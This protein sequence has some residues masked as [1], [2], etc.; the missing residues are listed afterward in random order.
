MRSVKIFHDWEFIDDGKTIDPIS[1]GMVKES[2]ES[3]FAIFDG[4]DAE[5]ADDWVRANVLTKLDP[6]FPR[7]SKAEIRSEV[8]AF[9]GPDHPE[10]WGYYAAY[11][12]VCLAQLF[13][14]MHLFPSGWPYL[15]LDI[16]QLCILLG[17]PRLPK[18]DPRN[19]HDA[20]SDALH[21]KHMYEF[22]RS[23]EAR[24]RSRKV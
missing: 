6:H 24:R 20:L 12:H 15:T 9:V 19:E 22:L 2:G 11:D 7:K 1:V 10:F 23:Y 18:Q 21:N 13:G 3:Y 8:F 16:K 5:K 4:Y 14:P 17:D